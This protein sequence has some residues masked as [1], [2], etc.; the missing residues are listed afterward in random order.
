M[1]ITR[2]SH[3]EADLEAQRRGKDVVAQRTFVSEAKSSLDYKPIN[4]CKRAC[5]CTCHKVYRLKSP[6]VLHN[7]VGSLLIKSNGLY[8][9]SQPCNEFS[10]QR[11]SSASIRLSY[12]FPEWL[13]N[14]MVS[15]IVISNQ[16]TGPQLSLVAP[17]IVSYKSKIFESAF[18]GNIDGIA[19]LFE[20]GLASPCDVS[21]DWGCTPL[22][23]AVD[24]GHMNLCRF[25]L[26]AGAR[27][28]IT[29]L[30]ENS[31]TDLVYNKIISKRVSPDEAAELEEMFN[32]DDWFEERQFSILHKIVLD[33]LPTPRDLDHELSASTKNIDLGDSE[34]RTPLSWA[35]ERGN[36]QDLEIL[37]C[38]GADASSRSITGLTPLHYAA[39]APTPTGLSILLKHGALA[40]AMNKWKQGPLN[41]A[42]YFQNDPAYI[43]PLLD[44]GADIN[45][46]DCGGCSVLTSATFMNN[47]RTARYLLSQ[48]ADIN[49]Q[50]GAGATA[51]NYSIRNNNHDCSALL[52]ELGADL[53]LE[54]Y[55]GETALHYLARHADIRTLEIFQAADLED[56]NPDA[57]TNARLTA[58]DVMKQRVD[59]NEE[60]ESAFRSLMAK[61]DSKSFCV[62]FFDASEKLPMSVGKVPDLVEVRVEEIIC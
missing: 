41:I 17:R 6:S 18:A 58:W 1:Q 8:G 19:T 7:V 25:L 4:P 3:Q 57:E 9:L 38:Y 50:D 39:K 32:K 46:R 40:T 11:N 20:L 26:K 59:M 13:L 10:C 12:R 35:A 24:K 44:A 16:L 45:E 31:V 22:H 27:P 56:M 54:N 47:V 53:S 48:G 23:Y 52:L 5:S 2:S 37:L 21:D 62:D 30:D 15:S 28:D 29:D 33:L 55:E 36:V 51:L 49:C 34:G 14:R 43:S 42:S 61:L 60:V